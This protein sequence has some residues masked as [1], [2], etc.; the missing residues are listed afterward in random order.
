VDGFIF[1]ITKRYNIFKLAEKEPLRGKKVYLK[2]K[3]LTPPAFT[4]SD[5]LLLKFKVDSLKI[6][7]IIFI[8][9]SILLAILLGPASAA[10]LGVAPYPFFLYFYL[11]K[12]KEK[13]ER[14]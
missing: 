14:G 3:K 4:G 1:I 8:T 9:I 10:M 2:G 5:I 7:L 12:N 13:R 11:Y 6:P